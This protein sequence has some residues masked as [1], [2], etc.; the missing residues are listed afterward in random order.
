LNAYRKV[1]GGDL[2]TLRARFQDDYMCNAQAS[3]VT[4][5]VFPTGSDLTVAGQ[6]LVLSGVATYFNEGIFEYNYT[7]PEIG[8]DGV[9]NDVW[10]G[11]LNNQVLSGVFNFEVSASGQINVLGSQLNINN[12][13]ELYIPSGIR[14]LDGTFLSDPVTAEFMTTVAPHYTDERKIRL[15]IGGWI[16]N[17]G[18]IVLEQGILEGSI[19]ADQ[20][21][22]NK[23][24][25][26]TAFYLHARR[27]WVT[28][29]VASMLLANL[30][31]LSLKAKTLAD[32]HVQYDTTAIQKVMSRLL[33]CQDR[34]LRQLMAGGYAIL[35]EQAKYVVKGEA[36]PDRPHVG[37]E[38]ISTEGPS[39]TNKIPGGNVKERRLFERRWKTGWIP[40]RY[41]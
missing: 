12:L 41:W 35:A 3:G 38:W 15:E 17:L 7:T 6:A 31:N 22:F 25:I 11:T 30:G 27:E 24:N 13:V 4:V 5:S 1:R 36:D 33:D 16:G 26:N 19:A 2:I 14:A 40:R 28:C 20:L 34:W 18:D 23:T 29:Y 8:P 37:R 32:L 39:W 10:Y 9:W 21:T